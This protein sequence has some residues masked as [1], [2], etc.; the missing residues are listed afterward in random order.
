MVKVILSL[1]IIFSCSLFSEV[2][3]RGIVTDEEDNP[4]I[5]ATVQVIS[6]KKGTTSDK[7]GKYSL[8]GDF[9][10]NTKITI[11]YI[12]RKTIEEE[13]DIKTNDVVLNFTMEEEAT[14]SKSLEVVSSRATFRETPIAFAKLTKEDLQ[15]RLGSRD[16]PM[17]LNE[18]PGVYATQSG[19]GYGDARVNVRGFNQRNVAVLVNGVPVNDMETGQV[20]WSNWDG[21]GNVMAELQ[22]QRGL[23]AGKLANPSVGGTINMITDAALQKPGFRFKQEVS[24]AP[25]NNL[26]EF[27]RQTILGYNTGKVGDFALSLLVG[28][29]DSEGIIDKLYFDAWNY[30]LGFSWDVSDE[31][32]IDVYVMGAP[33]EHGQRTFR[34]PIELYNADEARDLGIVISPSTASLTNRGILFNQHWGKYDR[35][36]QVQEFQNGSSRQLRY[37]NSLNERVNY[38]HKPQANINWHWQL[39]EKSSIT[40][41]FYVSTGEGGGSAPAGPGHFTDPLTGQINYNRIDSINRFNKDLK[42]DPDLS[43]S[44]RVIQNSVNNHFWTGWLGTYETKP[45]KGLTIQGGTDIRYYKG[46]H[47]REVR[48]LIGGDYYIQT[49]RRPVASGQETGTFVDSVADLNIQ[50]EIDK[51][52]ANRNANDSAK[53]RKLM[54]ANLGDKIDYN[55]NGYVNWLGGFGQVEYKFDNILTFLNVSLSNTGYKREDLFRLPNEVARTNFKWGA[56]RE[57][58]W[59]NFLGYTIKFGGNINLTEE[60]NLFTNIGYYS[61]PPLFNTVFAN[62]NTLFANTLNEKVMAFELG[63]GYRSREFNANLNLYLTDWRDRNWAVTTRGSDGN[64]YRYNLA[65]L[66]AR[67]M[68]IELDMRYR[69]I[70]ELQIRGF[71]SIGDWRWTNDIV[72]NFRPDNYSGTDLPAIKVY[73]QGLRVGD[74]AQTVLGLSF[75]YYPIQG[76]SINMTNNLFANHYSDFNPETRRPIVKQERNNIVEYIDRN[77]PWQIPAYYLSNL[78]VNYRIPFPEEGFDLWLVASVFNLFNNTYIADAT[79]NRT[80]ILNESQTARLHNADAAEV[81]FGNPRNFNLGLQIRF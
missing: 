47:W 40:N 74:A 26:G 6:A 51:L 16:I 61:R 14:L 21:L 45:I 19:G 42:Y 76:L 65:G 3:I 78:H 18:T 52:Y 37:D 77:Q 67:H 75:N 43:K 50:F 34:Q 54:T 7:Q 35:A 70:R 59:Q 79:D 9:K 71:A 41:V 33:Q 23:G 73:T 29:K 2:T 24:G 5:G 53:A 62:D 13:I 60:F 66:N 39:D 81:Y 22:V 64:D 28:R 68:G 58:E 15:T 1:I 4:L 25:N 56:G 20:F 11:K 55:Y 31:H 10:G 30:Y 44:T 36:S 46:L 63:A 12:G 38:F 27:Y 48:N 32:Q 17:I 69:P 57:T 72:A 8:K 49:I 80:G